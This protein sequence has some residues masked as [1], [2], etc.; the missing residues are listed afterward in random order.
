[1]QIE[2]ERWENV[3]ERAS[4]DW[5]WFYFWLDEKVARDLFSLVK[6]S[7]STFTFMCRQVEYEPEV[8]AAW[9]EHSEVRNKKTDDQYFPVRLEQARSVWVVD[10]FIY[11]FFIFFPLFYL[12]IAP[13][14]E[15]AIS[16]KG[17]S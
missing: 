16:W 14:S 15:G 11:L 4:Q 10:L 6:Q 7:E 1:M 17:V 8:V 13:Y 12:N 2:R 5:F 9:T 3:S